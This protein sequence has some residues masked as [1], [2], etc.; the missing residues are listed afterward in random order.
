MQAQS[1]LNDEVARLLQGLL[2][3]VKALSLA[4]ELL[5]ALVVGTCVFQVWLWMIRVV[6]PLAIV[7]V[8]Y[9]TFA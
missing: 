9:Q 1:D 8:V 5:A 7:G 2:D 6:A 4:L 3:L